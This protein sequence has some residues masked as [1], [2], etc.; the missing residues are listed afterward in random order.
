MP[1]VGLVILDLAS[2]VSILFNLLQ[3][4]WRNEERGARAGDNA[5]QER[6]GDE[7]EAEQRLKEQAAPLFFNLDGTPGPI[8]VTESQ[9]S[10]QGPLMYLWGLV[11]VVNRAQVPTKI[12]RSGF[13]WQ[14]R[15]GVFKAFPSTCNPTPRTDQTEL[16]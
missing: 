3:L 10:S 11:T 5:E 7:R 12:T 1:A 13:S 8:L 6:K 9:H 15:N 4:K 2:L 16:A 14:A